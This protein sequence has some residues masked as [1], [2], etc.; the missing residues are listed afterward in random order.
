MNI[1]VCSKETRKASQGSTLSFG[2]QTYQLSKDNQAVPLP[3]KTVIAV[4]TSPRFGM[5]AEYKGGV[6][7]VR[8]TVRPAKVIA[9]ENRV[10]RPILTSHSHAIISYRVE[11][12]V[13]NFSFIL[14]WEDHP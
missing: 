6:Y 5:R 2:G 8:K 3:N 4:L 9:K 14:H 12:L 13:S 7:Q 1:D 11:R 10:K